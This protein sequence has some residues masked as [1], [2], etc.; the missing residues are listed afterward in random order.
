MKKQLLLIPL[1]RQVLLNYIKT[2][3]NKKRKIALCSTI[4]D[5]EFNKIIK[6]L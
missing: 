6:Q 2:K 1:T 3:P 5:E 4:P